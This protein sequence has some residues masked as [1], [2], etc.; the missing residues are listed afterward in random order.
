MYLIFEP[1]ICL[2]ELI[3]FMQNIVN[4]NNFWTFSLKKDKK[5]MEVKEIVIQHLEKYLR[6]QFYLVTSFLFTKLFY[7]SS[8]LDFG[9]FKQQIY[10]FLLATDFVNRTL[11]MINLLPFDDLG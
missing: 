9:G 11:S 10:R 4:Q 3:T 7:K 8:S 5:W 6:R 2:V 1:R